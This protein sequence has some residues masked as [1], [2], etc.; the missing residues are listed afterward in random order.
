M[1]NEGSPTLLSEWRL[2]SSSVLTAEETA[3][4]RGAARL[5]EFL[6]EAP[7][8]APGGG[9]RSQQMS[10]YR[11]HVPALHNVCAQTPSSTALKRII[12]YFQQNVH[13]DNYLYSYCVAASTDNQENYVL[14]ESR[15]K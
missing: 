3:G 11:S 5:L 4:P 8:T 1:I 12:L 10:L 14:V 6:G 13:S 7:M 2:H 9:R 15:F